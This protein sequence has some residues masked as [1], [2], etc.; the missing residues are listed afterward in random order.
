MFIS[1]DNFGVCE[2]ITALILNNRVVHKR[3]Q[4][5]HHDTAKN[6]ISQKL[7]FKKGTLIILPGQKLSL[8]L[9]IVGGSE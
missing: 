7:I 5:T 6:K 8:G 3:G 1:I 2:N 9:D 4:T